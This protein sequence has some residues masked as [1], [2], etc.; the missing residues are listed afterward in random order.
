MDSGRKMH[1]RSVLCRGQR[2]EYG[3]IISAI[4]SETLESV[5]KLLAEQ[6]RGWVLAVLADET[7]TLDIPGNKILSLSVEHLSGVG[8]W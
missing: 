2:E 3:H 5:K 8:K 4:S 6:D 7:D 1:L